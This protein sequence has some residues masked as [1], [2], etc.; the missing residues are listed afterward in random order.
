MHRSVDKMDVCALLCLWTT[1]LPQLPGKGQLMSQ[2]GLCDQMPVLMPILELFYRH[3]KSELG[4]WGRLQ[5]GKAVDIT[6]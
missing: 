4:F 3:L 6:P 5:E 2:P 1:L